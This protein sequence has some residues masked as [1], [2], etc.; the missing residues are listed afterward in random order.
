M[1]FSPVA[2]RFDNPFLE[3]EADRL[4]DL[5]VKYAADPNLGSAD[6]ALDVRDAFVCLFPT[7][8]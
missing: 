5:S 3:T 6:T 1:P 7:H 8:A 2:P 4:K